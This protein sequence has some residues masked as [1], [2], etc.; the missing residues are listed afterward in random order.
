MSINSRWL[1]LGALLVVA[2]AIR[3]WL[4]RGFMGSDDV[5]YA[6]RGLE[7]LAGHWTPFDYNGALRYGVNLPI[8]AA[9]GLLGRSEGALAAWGLACSLGEIAIVYTYALR[10]WGTRV[11]VF[12]GLVLATI[13]QHIDSA[14]NIA[15]DAPFAALLTLSMVLLHFGV[16][17]GKAVTFVGAGLALGFAGWI[18]PEAALVFSMPFGIMALTFMQDRRQVLWLVLG[19]AAAA[20]LNLALFAWA[21]GDPFYYAH[22]LA[23][24]LKGGSANPASSQSHDANFYF[25]LLFLDG[26]T[27]WL[28][29]MLALLGAWFAVRT[30]DP[31]QRRTGYFTVLWICLLLLFFS[32]FVYSLSPLRLIPKQTNYAIIFAASISVL[33]GVALA[34]MKTGAAIA[35]MVLLGIG[36][37]FLA[38]LDG[39]GHHLHAATH[40]DT[41]RFAQANKSAVVFASGQTLNLNH[42]LGLMGQENASNLLPLKELAE[43]NGLQHSLP[44]GAQI[45]AAYYPGWPEAFGDV[46]PLFQGDPA[47]C[48]RQIAK[49]VGDPSVTE[50]VAT[51]I[52]STVRAS[53]PSW[54]DRHV[55]FTDK[56]LLPESVQF[57]SVDR[58]C[59]AQ[60]RKTALISSKINSGL[61]P[62]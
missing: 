17:T 12:A 32:F 34:R 35:L 36:G 53:L 55:R 62:K 19:A 1:S 51:R 46:A 27:L 15:A 14:T 22:V 16:S 23:R 33:A 3:L 60:I 30:Q 10:A 11:A 61:G 59:L 29:P 24:Q 42:V 7:V 57:Y 58:V 40:R 52:V 37:L 38:A 18:K 44:N 31:A 39:Y 50:I 26:R 8:A 45:I 9:V 56:L 4:F 47:H 54:A 5:I 20:S 48:M 13:P 25:R 43:A 28:A 2:A 21:F 41:I 49:A 6:T